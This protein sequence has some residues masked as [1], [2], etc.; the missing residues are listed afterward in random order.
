MVYIF[1]SGIHGVGKTTLINRLKKDN[2]KIKCFSASDLIRNSGK[3]INNNQKF[4]SDIDQNQLLLKQELLKITDSNQKFF[5]DGHFCL[6]NKKGNIEN[7]SFFTLE[8]TKLEKIVFLEENPVVICQRLFDRDG[9]KYDFDTIREFQKA[10][11][12]QAFKFSKEKDVPI[13]IYNNE[14][15]FEELKQF[16]F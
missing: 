9:K 8:G 13:F 4:T 15:S 2:K 5:L 11:K 16:V 10:E 3:R 6:L 12:V 14:S 7:V 1:F